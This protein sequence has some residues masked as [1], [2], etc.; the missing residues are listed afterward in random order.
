MDGVPWIKS[1]Y[2]ISCKDQTEWDDNQVDVYTSYIVGCMEH[3]N[4]CTTRHTDTLKLPQPQPIY[5]FLA[6]HSQPGSLGHKFSHNWG[7][8]GDDLI[9]GIAIF[10]SSAMWY[11]V[12]GR[13]I[14]VPSTTNKT[15]WNW[16]QLSNV[17]PA[18]RGKRNPGCLLLEVI[19][20]M[21]AINKKG[22]VAQLWSQWHLYGM[23]SHVSQSSQ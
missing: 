22:S 11:V 1:K 20:R 21:K 3:V 2:D 12:L 23:G 10:P 19:I 17:S 5:P 6:Q 7:Q 4:T 15:T 18:G 16:K 14:Q 9:N 8:A 13:H